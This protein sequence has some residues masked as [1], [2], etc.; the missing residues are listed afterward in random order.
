M[1]TAHL[2]RRLELMEPAAA[3]QSGGGLRVPWVEIVTL[4]VGAALIVGA[5]RWARVLQGEGVR[6]YLGAPPLTGSVHPRLP[7]GAA[8]VALFAALAVW[9]GPDIAQRVRFRALTWLAA[10]GAAV[11]AALLA[12]TDGVTG[13][14]AP[15]SVPWEYLH[16]VGRVGSPGAF[17]RGFVTN[18]GTY[19]TH[20]RAHPPGMLM[21]LWSLSR[22]GLQG[23]WGVVAIEF[24]GGAAA[25]PAVLITIRELAG[26]ERARAAAPFLVLVPFAVTFGS[27]DALFMGV[28]AWA[29]ASLIMATGRAGR[30]CATWAALG[31]VLLGIGLMLSYG[32]VLLALLPAAVILARRRIA[33]GAIGLAGVASVIG[34]FALAGFRWWEGFAATRVQYAESIARW[35]PSRYFLI[36]NLAA[37][38]I[39][40]GPATWVGL[41]R[42]RDRRVW[43]VTGASLAAIALADLSGLSKGEVERIWLPFMPWMVAG[44]AWGLISSANRSRGPVRGTTA[45]RWLVAQVLWAVGLQLLVRSPW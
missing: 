22:A 37:L 6:L 21:L 23:P 3:P 7:P 24:L 44:A 28:G 18:I 31:G 41:V 9:R 42:L 35:R 32:L 33:V 4:A 26:E 14:T 40:V 2:S 12:L 27:G 45:R 11:W 29:C 17:L 16:D 39:A 36:A 43:L 19:T 5:E 20:V 13:L 38:A 1:K 25:I 10:L 34:A 30:R 8:L 15:V